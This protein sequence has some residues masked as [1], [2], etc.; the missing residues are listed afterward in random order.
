M[1]F[2]ISTIQVAD[3]C[4]VVLTNPATGEDTF[5]LG[6]KDVVIDGETVKRPV[7]GQLSVTV[8]SPA[9][10]PFKA[11][12]AAQSAKMVKRIKAK[13]KTEETPEEIA[14]TTASFLAAI[15][16]SLN[17][18]DY[19]GQSSGVETFRALYAD[20]KM[21]WLTEQVNREAGDWANFTQA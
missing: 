8:H 3:T 17:G 14:A 21:G 9:S 4:D 5:K 16:V 6:E 10:K 1:S 15:T 19:Q 20:P 12:Q 2:D 18:F 13:G 11:A 7:Y